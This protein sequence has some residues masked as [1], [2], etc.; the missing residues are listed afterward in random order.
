MFPRK[1]SS[2]I[3]DWVL[4]TSSPTPALVAFV[5]VIFRRLLSPRRIIC[6]HCTRTRHVVCSRPR[7]IRIIVR[8]HSS[9]SPTESFV[10]TYSPTE[11]FVNTHSP[12]SRSS[13]FYPYYRL[14]YSSSPPRHNIRVRRSSSSSSSPPSCLHVGQ[15]ACVDGFSLSIP[16]LQ[17]SVIVPSRIR[18]QIHSVSIGPSLAFAFCASQTHAHSF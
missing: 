3:F 15:F 18:F 8:P 13:S 12:R 7:F 2:Y 1:S 4:P 5:L 11:S 9:Y 16:P 6:S 17:S 14:S 10:Y